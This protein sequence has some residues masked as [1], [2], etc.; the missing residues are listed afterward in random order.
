MFILVFWFDAF[1]FLDGLQNILNNFNSLFTMTN[2]F[3]NILIDK[4]FPLALVL[5]PAL[6]VGPGAGSGGGGERTGRGGVPVATLWVGFY[7]LG[8]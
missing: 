8:A 4:E 2:Y 3:A 6:V 1:L 5:V 7:W